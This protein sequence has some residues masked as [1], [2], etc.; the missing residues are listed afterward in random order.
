V[1]CGD[2][3]AIGGSAFAQSPTFS[4][5]TRRGGLVSWVQRSTTDQGTLWA[6]TTLGRLFVSHNANAANPDDVVLT[7]IDNLSGGTALPGR[8]ISSIYVDPTDPNHAWVSYL[9][10]NSATPGFGGHVF[11]VTYDPIGGTVSVQ[12]VD[13]NIGDQPVNAVVENT[14]G[15]LYAATDFGVYLLPSGGN[16]WASAASGLPVVTVASLTVNPSAHQL[17]AATHGR[18]A[19]QLTLP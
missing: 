9:G 14:N 10:Y 13:N 19:Y 6:S 12:S 4:A 7:R 1:T 15:D 16:A 17:L 3:V 18:G 2:W 11:S 8:A 5:G